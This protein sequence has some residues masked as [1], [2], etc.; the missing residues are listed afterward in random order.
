MIHSNWSFINPFNDCIQCHDTF[1]MNDFMNIITDARRDF[2]NATYF[3][4]GFQ[5]N[6]IENFGL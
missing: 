2:I 4:D 5:T 3:L 1:K 6:E